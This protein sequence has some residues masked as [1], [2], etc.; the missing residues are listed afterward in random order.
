MQRC[1]SLVIDVTTTLTCLTLGPRVLWR[2]PA[3]VVMIEPENRVRWLSHGGVLI[4]ASFEHVRPVP[5][6]T[7]N[8]EDCTLPSH[9]A[10]S[11]LDAI[12]N[13]GTTRC[14]DLVKSSQ[15]RASDD[16][17]ADIDDQDMPDVSI[18][19]LANLRALRKQSLTL[20]WMNLPARHQGNWSR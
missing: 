10:K 5:G 1:S 12:R 14:F 7:P 15:R 3:I 11:G 18:G 9:K 6:S 19:F 17:M 4:R 16:E 20:A 2:G 8:E 13:R